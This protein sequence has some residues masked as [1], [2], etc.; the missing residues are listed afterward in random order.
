M[1]KNRGLDTSRL[2]PPPVP[3]G[4]V[5]DARLHLLD[6]QVLDVDDVPVTTVDDIE[7]S[8]PEPDQPIPPGTDPPHITALLTGPVLGTRIFGG[9]PP[10]SRLIRIPWDVVSGVGTVISVGVRS[11][12]LDASWVE[13][14]LRNHVIGRIPGGRHDPD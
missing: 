11:D 13:R 4:L 8:G 10:S 3:A 7:L 9:R 6:R 2:K 1:A 12:S 14:W 5:L